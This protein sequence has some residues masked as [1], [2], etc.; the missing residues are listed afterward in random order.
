[1]TGDKKS[2]ISNCVSEKFGFSNR[3]A[4]VTSFQRIVIAM[5]NQSVS[6]SPIVHRLHQLTN[7]FFVVIDDKLVKCLSLDSREVWFEQEQVEDGIILKIRTLE[8]VFGKNKCE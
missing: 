5:S 6:K 3:H 2:P 4:T 1:M 7:F 8:T